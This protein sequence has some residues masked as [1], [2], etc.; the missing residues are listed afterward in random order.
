[1]VSI[2]R[3]TVLLSVTVFNGSIF[4]NDKNRVFRG[5]RTPMEF[6]KIILWLNEELQLRATAFKISQ[7]AL[8]DDI[9]FGERFDTGEEVPA[10]DKDLVF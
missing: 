8:V 7:E 6:Y 9:S 2:A 5:R 10:I 4:Y 3:A 1:M